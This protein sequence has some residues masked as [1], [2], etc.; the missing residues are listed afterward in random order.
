MT[1]ILYI[2]SHEHLASFS[3]KYNYRF[4]YYEDID[5]KMKL[6]QSMT[7]IGDKYMFLS[8]PYG[9]ERFC[10]CLA[11]KNVD[12]DQFESQYSQRN[13]NKL[14]NLYDNVSCVIMYEEVDVEALENNIPVSVSKYKCIIYPEP[15]G[16]TI[17][18]AVPDRAPKQEEE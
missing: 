7:K 4:A 5:D 9:V 8:W 18:P 17:K 14:E 11:Y 16:S 15:R 3:T 13:W 6:I 12:D 1:K 10:T 2:H